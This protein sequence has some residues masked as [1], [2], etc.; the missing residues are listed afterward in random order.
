MGVFFSRCFF[1]LAHSLSRKGSGLW[2]GGMGWD[3][4]DRMD[5]MGSDGFL[6]MGGWIASRLP[7]TQIMRTS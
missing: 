1:S 7:A 6:R 3:E 5:M 4:T 2:V